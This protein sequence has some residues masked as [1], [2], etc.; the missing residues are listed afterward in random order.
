[1]VASSDFGPKPQASP[2]ALWTVL[3]P[4]NAGNNI[5]SPWN[6]FQIEELGDW[7][8]EGFDAIN[9]AIAADHRGDDSESLESLVE[10]FGNPFKHHCEENS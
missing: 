10:L 7:F 8:E 9:R 2:D 4:V 6:A 3:D 5:V 1:L